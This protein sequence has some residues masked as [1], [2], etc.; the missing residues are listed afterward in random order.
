M[1]G[2]ESGAGDK[3][4]SDDLHGLFRE[5]EKEEEHVDLSDIRPDDSVVFALFWAL[6]GVVLLQVF[7]RYVL[8][9]SLGWTEEIARYL[10]IGVTFVGSV[11]AMRKGSH[12]TVEALLKY[13]PAPIR[14]WMLVL[15]DTTV[16]LFCIFLAW[17]A[18]RL[19]DRTNQFMVTIDISKSVIYWAVCAGFAGMVIYSAIRLARRLRRRE[20]DELH[21]LTLD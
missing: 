13:L 9:N 10:L 6:F 16:V 21:T 8:N 15:V 20:S 7:T 18:A 19:A 4:A 5:W 11:M 3:P 14:H 17:T 2:K 12:I 1:A